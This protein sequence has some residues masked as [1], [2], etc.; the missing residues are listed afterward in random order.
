MSRTAIAALLM[1]GG[2]SAD[3]AA[4]GCSGPAELSYQKSDATARERAS[5]TGGYLV[6]EGAWPLDHLKLSEFSKKY[7]VV[8]GA[9]HRSYAHAIEKKTMIAE[10]PPMVSVR[11][12]LGNEIA[13]IDGANPDTD[14]FTA[15]MEGLPETIAAYRR[16]CVAATARAE[17]DLQ[18]GAIGSDTVAELAP[19]AD[20]TGYAEAAAAA[21][22]WARLIA[23]GNEELATAKAAEDRS[24]LAKLARIYAGTAVAEAATAAR[25]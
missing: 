8:A 11:D 14:R 18:R 12:A 15:L 13:R 21:A 10:A 6:L 22:A 3:L 1:L 16:R 5:S 9:A 19:F 2:A 17:K 25:N 7:P 23:H 20:D 4:C 24:A